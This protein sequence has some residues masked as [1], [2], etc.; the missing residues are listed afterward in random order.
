M[1][2]QDCQPHG[3]LPKEWPRLHP[4]MCKCLR[5]EPLGRRRAIRSSRPDQPQE[6]ADGSLR[7]RADLPEKITTHSMGSDID[8]SSQRL[9]G[10][11][12]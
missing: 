11:P 10:L 3:L 6:P 7:T 9:W 5:H 12:S 2:L 8:G 4:R 1:C